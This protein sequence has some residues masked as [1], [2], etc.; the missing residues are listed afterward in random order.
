MN[1]FSCFQ[2]IIGKKRGPFQLSKGKEREYIIKFYVFWQ[3][4]L[5]CL[6]S[7]F[8]LSASFRFYGQNFIY[9]HLSCCYLLFSPFSSLSHSFS[10]F[11]FFFSFFFC[12]LHPSA[13]SN[14]VL[15]LTSI[16][17]PEVLGQKIF[18][19][20]PPTNFQP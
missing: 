9:W 13:K 12:L 5:S 19:K 1:S 2:C 10:L 15:V 18:S 17:N 16:S 6:L 4:S 14:T 7:V 8:S 3:I 20:Q 11:L